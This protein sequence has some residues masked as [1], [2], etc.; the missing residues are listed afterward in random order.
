MS[1]DVH[2][3]CSQE[4]ADQ[5]PS[6]CMTYHKAA[7]ANHIQ[8]VVLDP[9]VRGERFVDQAS[10]PTRH[11][12]GD[13][14]GTHTTAADGH[15]AVPAPPGDGPGQGQDN[16]RIIIIGVESTLTELNDLV[17]GRT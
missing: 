14:T 2:E 10:P 4:C 11:L 9:L 17:A 8:I 16:I 7:Q 13:N 5:F 15:P 1:L 12:V 3:T 6:K